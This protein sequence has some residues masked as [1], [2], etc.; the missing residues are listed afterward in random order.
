[1]DKSITIGRSSSCDIVIPDNRVS[2]NHATLSIVN[3][4]YVYRD[5]STNGSTL[6][7]Q[8]IT[9]PVKITPGA[10]IMLDGRVPLPWAQIY[11]RL[12]LSGTVAYGSGATQ[13]GEIPVVAKDPEDQAGFGW[14]LLAFLIPLVGLILYFA[15]RGNYPN[16]AN[17]VGIW[18]LIG[19]VIN[20]IAILA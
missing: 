11:A 10:P 9:G 16:K 4:T 3:G 13:V 12:P 20:L 1:M 15:W 19:F 18:A 5:T 7:G 14:C 17:T 6:N 8:I 2:R